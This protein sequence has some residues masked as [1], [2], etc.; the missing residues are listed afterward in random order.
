MEEKNLDRNSL[1]SI[2]PSEPGD[3]NFIMATWLRG[4]RYGNDWFEAIDSEIYFRVYGLF[5][6]K[7]IADKNTSV[8]VACL[9]D[10]PDVI[11]GYSVSS[12]PVVHWV[13]CKKSWRNIG[14]AKSLVPKTIE[15]VTHLTSVG[16]SILRRSP[17]VKFDPFN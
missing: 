6:E 4:L 14:I 9:K 16:R 2:R 8:N 7:I 11:L 13:F 5:I 1:I 10:D 12:G 15:K 3:H 17:N